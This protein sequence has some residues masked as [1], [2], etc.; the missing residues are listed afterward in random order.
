MSE[1]FGNRDEKCVQWTGVCVCVCVDPDLLFANKNGDGVDSGCSLEMRGYMHQLL[2][3]VSMAAVCLQTS[4]HWHTVNHSL[5]Q[6]HWLTNTI[7]NTHSTY[8]GKL[9]H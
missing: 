1:K 5:Q 3:L 4:H 8:C 6:S 9:M 2:M 7:T